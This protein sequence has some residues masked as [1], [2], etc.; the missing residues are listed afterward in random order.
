MD[1][2]GRGGIVTIQERDG[3]P[4]RREEALSEAGV[5]KKRGRRSVFVN[6]YGNRQYLK[7]YTVLDS[8]VDTRMHKSGCSR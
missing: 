7:S 6:C 3:W 5:S 2:F 1:V 8:S 4:V